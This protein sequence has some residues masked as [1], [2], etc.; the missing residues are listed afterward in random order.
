MKRKKS[1]QTRMV[2]ERRE[3]EGSRREKRQGWNQGRHENL[4]G[5]EAEGS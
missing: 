1:K 5:S 3:R 4:M 2:R